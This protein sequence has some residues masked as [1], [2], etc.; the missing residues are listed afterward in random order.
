MKYGLL[1]VFCALPFA[2]NANIA[3]SE[4]VNNSVDTITS[5]LQSKADDNKVVHLSGANMNDGATIKFSTYGNRFVTI[6]GNSIVADMSK[7]TGGW[8]GS[9]ASV[10]DPVADDTTM[11]GWYGG[12]SGLTYIYMG[13]TYSTPMMKMTKAGDFTFAKPVVVGAPTDD[14]TTS[15]QVDTVGARN[16]KINSITSNVQD[17]ATNSLVDMWI[18]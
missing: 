14:T 4:Y 7:T 1:L 6:S 9:F 12:T 5:A 17:N 15:K 10:K 16:L 13:G 11:L 2:A 18:E 8:A 3:S